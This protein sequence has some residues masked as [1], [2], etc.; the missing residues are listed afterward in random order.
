M[1][2]TVQTTR[3]TFQQQ[4]PL[5]LYRDI[6]KGIRGFLFD[7]TT[8]A[9]STDPG[10]RG[11]RSDLARQPLIERHAPDLAVA[12]AL[13]HP[14]LERRIDGL[15]ALGELARDVD[16]S[17]ARSALHQLHL[18]LAAFTGDYL[19]H[20]DLEEREVMRVLA[21]A[22]SSEE[23]L[24]VHQAIVGSIPPHE[25]AA[26][27]LHML[28]AM[29]VDDR[30]ELLGG[31]RQGMPPEAFAGVWA[32]AGSVLAPADLAAVGGRLGIG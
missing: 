23:V 25:M 14:A 15:V 1:T 19:A 17:D 24:E 11:A 3:A 2:D 6:H 9:G 29:N 18:D 27:L 21:N 26:G 10:D 4:V 31:A 32:L 16:G 12:V 7:V 22:M 30:T 13:D 28:P 8:A 5:D 20:Q